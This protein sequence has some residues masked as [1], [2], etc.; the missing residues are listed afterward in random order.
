MA[1]NIDRGN[2]LVAFV[3]AGLGDGETGAGVEEIDKRLLSQNP[4]LQVTE[5]G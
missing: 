2:E 5:I 4:L 1:L 3:Q